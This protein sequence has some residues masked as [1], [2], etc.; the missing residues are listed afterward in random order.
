MTGILTAARDLTCL[1]L[2]ILTGNETWEKVIDG[3]TVKAFPAWKWL[4]TREL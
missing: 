1:N 2:T 4:L 3:L